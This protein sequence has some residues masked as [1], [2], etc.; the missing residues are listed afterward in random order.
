MGQY[1]EGIG[2]TDGAFEEAATGSDGGWR[3]VVD[4]AGERSL[5][6]ASGVWRWMLVAAEVVHGVSL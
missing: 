4:K 2:Y 1:E 5:E 3:K 6:L